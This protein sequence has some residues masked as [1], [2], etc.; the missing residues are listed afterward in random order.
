MLLFENLN[1]L[2]LSLGTS[3]KTEVICWLSHLRDVTLPLHRKLTIRRM[4]RVWH[5]PIQVGR[6]YGCSSLECGTCN[7]WCYCSDTLLGVRSPQRLIFSRFRRAVVTTVVTFP[8]LVWGSHYWEGHPTVRGPTVRQLS[9]TVYG[10]LKDF[11]GLLLDS[12]HG[13][14]SENVTIGTWGSV[15]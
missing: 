5:Q 8:T 3:P 6:T 12:D 10:Q 1:N 7:P 15:N 14:E 4:S 9:H 11:L 2:W 13:F